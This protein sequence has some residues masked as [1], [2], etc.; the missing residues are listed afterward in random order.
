MIQVI[1]AFFRD[2]CVLVPGVLDREEIAALRAKTDFFAADLDTPSRHKTYVGTTFV[3]RFCH[4]LDPLFAD[5]AARDSLV[6]L[7][8]AVLE[9]GAA[10]NAMNVIRNEPG[11]AIAR[12]H[13]D[14]VVEFPLPEEIARFDVR[15]RMPVFWLT[16]Q[17]PL[18]DIDSLEDGPT[19]FVPGSQYS[20]R[21]PPAGENPEFE[22][23]GPASV[24]CKAGDVYL[25]NHQCWHRGAPNVSTH[26]R[27][28]MQIQYAQ[29][30]AD[31]R[32]KGIA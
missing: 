26:T 7:A 20:G 32:F 18:S 3:L 11:Q 29:R 24:L 16:L 15:M 4:E 21:R 9:S 13:V 28:L 23:R 6:S 8:A 1:E 5:I 17:I 31:R 10:F 22:G 25:F 30:W 27:Y 12:W 14:D 2:G 19:Q